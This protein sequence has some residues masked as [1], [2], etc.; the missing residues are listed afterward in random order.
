MSPAGVPN[1][2]LYGQDFATATQ[3]GL[4]WHQ[5]HVTSLVEQGDRMH[6]SKT[7]LK[8]DLPLG[9]AGTS[10]L[11][12]YQRR[13]AFK[14]VNAGQTPAGNIRNYNIRRTTVARLG[15]SLVN[16]ARH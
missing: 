11:D 2:Y 3:N 16:M 7:T 4:R 8:I 1:F 15:T 5:H 12:P 13:A 14:R 6:I 10:N 9:M